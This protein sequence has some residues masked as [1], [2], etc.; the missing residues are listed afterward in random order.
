MATK[1]KIEITTSSGFKW[2][3]D[4]AIGNDLEI[5]D[6][7]TELVVGRGVNPPSNLVIKMLGEDGKKALYD[8]HRDKD[9]RVMADKVGPDL[10]EILNEAAKA[11][12]K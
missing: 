3:I 1:K 12:K 4:P 9:G 5:I 10:N 11:L 6:E 2:K 8:H 7:F